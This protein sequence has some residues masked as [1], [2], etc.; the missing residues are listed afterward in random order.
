MTK[1]SSGKSSRPESPTRTAERRRVMDNFIKDD[2]MSFEE[3]QKL[4]KR[5]NDAEKN[6]SKFFN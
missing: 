5:I 3:F 1:F 4:M 6:N 2:G